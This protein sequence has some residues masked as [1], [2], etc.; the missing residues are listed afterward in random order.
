MTP[1]HYKAIELELRGRIIDRFWFNASYTW[2]QAK[3]TNPGQFEPITW[4]NPLG[5]SYDVSGF[6]YHAKFPDGHP[7]QDQIDYLYGGLGGLEFG[8]EGRKK[9]KSSICFTGRS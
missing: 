8:D 7:A 9:R 5:M 4:V 1:R 6:G 3:G 2:S